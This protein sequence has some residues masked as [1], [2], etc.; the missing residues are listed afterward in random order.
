MVDCYKM[1]EP[2]NFKLSENVFNK[3]RDLKKSKLEIEDLTRFKIIND[4]V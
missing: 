4:S 1:Q 2:K 3:K